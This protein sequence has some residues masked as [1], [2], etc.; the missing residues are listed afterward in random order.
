V[1]DIRDISDDFLQKCIVIIEQNLSDEGFGVTELAN[2]VGMSR[3]NLLRKVQKASG[4]SASVF[5]RKVRL[6]N[7]QSLIR[8][9][10]LNVSEVSYQVGFG[11]PSYFIKCYREEFGHPPGSEK[12]QFQAYSDEESAEMIKSNK[13]YLWYAGAVVAAVLTMWLLFFYPEKEPEPKEKSIMVLPFVND[14]DDSTNI[15]VING[16]M[17]SILNNLQR[18]EDLRVVSR[19]TSER[20]RNTNKSIP[21]IAAELGVNYLIEGSGQ[22]QGDQLMLNV[23]LIEASGDHHLWSEQYRRQSTDIFELQA[24]VAKDIAQQ[25]E[26]KIAPEEIE[27]IEKVLTKNLVAYDHYLKGLEA[28]NQENFEGIAIGVEEF[29]KAIAADPAFAEAY[30]Y[31][32]IGYYYDD[33]YR[34]QKTYT[35]E[36]QSYAKKAYSLEKKSP[37]TLTARGLAAM[38]RYDYEEAIQCFEDVVAL[39]PNSARAYN[40]LSDIYLFHAPDAMKYLEYALK[41]IKI[42]VAGQDST[43]LSFAYL[44]ISNALVQTGFIEI[45]EEFIR[46]SMA[47]DTANL[48]AEYLY[49]YIKFAKD[50]DFDLVE[51]RLIA[52][53]KKDTTRLD[54]LQEIAKVNYAQGNYQR[55]VSYY[56]KMNHLKMLIGSTLFES[57]DVKIGYSL[58]QIG[59][60]EEAQF[61][62]DRYRAYAEK[63]ES[64]YHHLEMAAY[65]A[66]QKKI[67]L[68]MEHLKQFAKI[69]SISYWFILFIKEDPILLELSG[70][71]DF[72]QTI[73]QIYNTF[74]QEHEKISKE[75]SKAEVII[76]L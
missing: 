71:P 49:A 2:E 29:K 57:E 15:Y 22:K 31:I 6:A 20:F 66:S 62:Y 69:E 5:I 38:H 45:S 60:N 40:Y 70:H 17:E 42:D 4:Y 37:T 65:Y 36:I 68:G 26:A 34:G 74:W 72:D 27:L 76:S 32:A 53:S 18:I 14:S 25:I 51:K 23:Q 67:E 52:A 28:I 47:L 8:E 21:E 48:F 9:T 54:I 44:H 16:L 64:I 24:E 35:T 58:E 41:G 73:E 56:E 30:A 75:L 55:A 39:N 10:N 19:T 13:P 12:E 59:R 50:R 43:S 11:S 46:Q 3:S 1:S 63:D 7:A 61:Y 33:F